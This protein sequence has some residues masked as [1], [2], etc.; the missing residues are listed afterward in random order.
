MSE[1]LVVDDDRN[2]L[3][4]TGDLLRAYGY[5]PVLAHTPDDA[6]NLL[7]AEPDR[8]DVILLD[9]KLRCPIDGDMI[10]KLVKR[11][12]PSF[13]TPIIF[14]TA[15]TQISSKYLIRLGA[16]DALAKPVRAEE[17]IDAIERA[18]NRKAPENPHL[19]APSELSS[20]ELK[21]HE[22]A[23]RIIDALSSTRTIVDAAKSL[24]CSR[25][26]L[27]RWLEK[28]GLHEFIITKEP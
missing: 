14:I 7:K 3:E 13:K 8:F 18:L 6:L 26:S 2:V 24:G 25:R 12:F 10:L 27:Y 16:Y 9:W 22:L 23:G 15:H 17:L 19:R 5:E 11:L 4:A 1:I 21:K 20:H 28:T